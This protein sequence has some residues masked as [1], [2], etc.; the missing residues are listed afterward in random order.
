MN[1]QDKICARCARVIEPRKKWLSQ[2]EQIKYCSEQCRKRRELRSY[3]TQI[4]ELLRTRGA[5]KTICPSEL[6]NEAERQNKALMEEVRISAR[7]LVSLG[8]I[9]I[10]QK[11]KIVDPSKAK[12]PIRL[13]LKH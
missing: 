12:G 1:T 7:R 9:V 8:A 2:W 4:L 3:E 13:K 10:T 6:L 11:G 5:G